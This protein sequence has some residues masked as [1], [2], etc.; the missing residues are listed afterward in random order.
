MDG[1]PADLRLVSLSPEQT[2]QAGKS[3]AS[4]LRP[5][6]VVLVSGDVGTGKTTFVRGACRGLGVEQRV[7]SPSFTIG[8]LYDGRFPVAHLDLFRLES[9]ADED[10]A[11]LSDYVGADVVTFVEWPRAAAAW[12][13]PAEVVMTLS[14]AHAGGDRRAVEAAGEAHLCERLEAVLG[15]EDP[16][17]QPS[18]RR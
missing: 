2:E 8:H 4:G 15:G 6:Q 7:T 1:A 12:T 18:P 14:L 16:P 9:L 10:P 5:G 3:V 11:L 17:G 13:G